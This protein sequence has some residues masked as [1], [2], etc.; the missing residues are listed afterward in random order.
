MKRWLLVAAVTAVVIGVGLSR[1]D[2]D[3]DV[4]GLLPRDSPTVQGL[5]LYQDTF[6][7][8]AELM[9]TVRSPDAD[10]TEDAARSLASA[11]ENEGLTE[12]ALWRDPFR[13]DGEALG[14]LLAFLWFNG[15]PQNF[16]GLA[17]RF[18]DD[19]LAPTLA[20]TIDRMTTSLRADEIGRLSH[21]P[22]AITSLPPGVESPISR[23]I[24][25]PFASP[26]G[27]FR[28][29]FVEFPYDDAGYLRC[30]S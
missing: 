13:D 28:V 18:D 24:E 21:D 6:G 22:Y 10:Q 3:A 27:L 19:R 30:R 12:R 11:L 23:A 26:D 29:L 14:E 20:D 17:N 9:L 15:P 1:F 8:T 5:K 4:F 25:D 7:S 16:A 2:L